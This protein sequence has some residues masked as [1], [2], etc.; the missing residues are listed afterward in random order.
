V[1]SAAAAVTTVAALGIPALLA[2]LGADDLPPSPRPPGV[3]VDPGAA[4]Q[5]TGPAGARLAPPRPHFTVEAR[6]ESLAERRDVDGLVEALGQPGAMRG[7]DEARFRVQALAALGKVP[8]ERAGLIL[9]GVAGDCAREDV[10]RA[11]A[12][13]AL[14]ERGDHATVGALA[15]ESDDPVVRS[16]APVLMARR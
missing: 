15:V 9:R 14:W 3:A 8:G 12:V 4:S 10:E 16:K 6:L 2:L 13:G 11:G 1:R 7:P 5:H